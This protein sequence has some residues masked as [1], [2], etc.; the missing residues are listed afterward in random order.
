MLTWTTVENLFR[1]CIKERLT[2]TAEANPPLTGSSK[3]LPILTQLITE[4]FSFH[5]LI[6]QAYLQSSPQPSSGRRKKKTGG[7]TDYAGPAAAVCHVTRSAI[8]AM[9]GALVEVKSWVDVQL[10]SATVDATVDATLAVIE[11][12][13][14]F[15][16]VQETAHGGVHDAG[17]RISRAL[18]SWDAADVARRL[19]LGQRRG[20]TELRRICELKLKRLDSWRS[21]V[22]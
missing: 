21:V 4:A 22:S 16:R 17:E 13:E 19:V 1:Q 12:G 8:E 10:G 14:V 5:G 11:N 7:V 3:G 9:G 6:I 2:S 15:R 20:L 18:H